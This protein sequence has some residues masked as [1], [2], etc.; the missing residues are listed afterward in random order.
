MPPFSLPPIFTCAPIALP[1]IR[2]PPSRPHVPFYRLVSH[3]RPTKWSLYRPLLKFAPDS[4]HREAV[5]SRW[6]RPRKRHCTSAHLTIRLLAAEEQ[7]LVDYKRLHHALLQP[8]ALTASNKGQVPVEP[9]PALLPTEDSRPSVDSLENPDCSPMAITPYHLRCT[10]PDSTSHRLRGVQEQ[11]EKL[12]LEESMSASAVENYVSSVLGRG[13]PGTFR[14]GPATC[15]T[16]A[17]DQL[18]S[19]KQA[20]SYYRPIQTPGLIFPSMLNAGMPRLK[21]QPLHMTMLMTHRQRAR[22]RRIVQ[23][24]SWQEMQM[25]MSLEEQFVVSVGLKGERNLCE[26]RI[27]LVTSQS[28]LT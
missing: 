1:V 5:R 4:A 2:Q 25:H 16:R 15:L 8:E 3:T 18:T 26:Q 9:E 28:I 12:Q 7:T 27:C 11:L 14:F 6:R 19:L 21:P 22:D 13:C 17:F 23:L 10:L 20:Y 24:K